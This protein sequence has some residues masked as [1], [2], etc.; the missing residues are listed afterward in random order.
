MSLS[1]LASLGTL[2]SG[3]AV[4]V[5]LVFLYQ[6]LRQIGA[7]IEQAEKNQRASIRAER[8][9][10]TVD[11][12][13]TFAEPSTADAVFKGMSADEDMSLTQIRQFALYCACRFYNLEDAYSQHADGLLDETAFANMTATLKNG[14]T[15][16]GMRVGWRIFRTQFGA[17]GD[18]VAFVDALLAETPLAGIGNPASGWRASLA[19]ERAAMPDA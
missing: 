5:S 14:F 15:Q 7:Q 1:D 12:I 19:A 6:Q 10:R 3:V 2:I 17:D 11:N 18:F 16:P 4:L 13:Q 9:S 8:T